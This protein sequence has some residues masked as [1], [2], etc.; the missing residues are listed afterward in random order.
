MG[1][2]GCPGCG[3]SPEARDRSEGA[4]TPGYRNALVTSRPEG[5]V[6]TG[7]SIAPSHAAPA[8][9]RCS[10]GALPAS[11]AA[12]PCESEEVLFAAKA[13]WGLR[14]RQAEF[15]EAVTAEVGEFVEILVP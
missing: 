1:S 8:P 6:S 13:N 10:L 4:A 9:S 15:M 12:E 7:E 11:A 5:H 14:K 3:H 2:A